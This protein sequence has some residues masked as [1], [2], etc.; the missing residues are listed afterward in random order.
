MFVQ[1]V[2]GSIIRG[3]RSEVIEE[4]TED[5]PGKKIRH[6][7]VAKASGKAPK[8]DADGSLCATCHIHLLRCACARAPET[9]EDRNP[10]TKSRPS[11]AFVRRR[12]T[13]AS[14]SASF[15]T[16]ATCARSPPTATSRRW[17][18]P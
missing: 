12:P 13:L 1:G 6:S 3:V 14:W 16:R 15:R 11:D 5:D 2:P 9:V 7:L 8:G 18:M 4:E 10:I 17:Q